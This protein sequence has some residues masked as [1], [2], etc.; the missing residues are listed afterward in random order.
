MRETPDGM[1]E[2]RQSSNDE[3]MMVKSERVK[4]RLHM[5][6]K[7]EDEKS[8]EVMLWYVIRLPLLLWLSSSRP[9]S[10][11]VTITLVSA[12]LFSYLV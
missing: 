1:K 6:N 3:M 9:V 12:A 4:Q 7:K 5:I 11:C 2:R 8:M 10:H